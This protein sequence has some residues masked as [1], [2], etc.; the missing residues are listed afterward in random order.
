MRANGSSVCVVST[1]SQSF[2]LDDEN[3]SEV[4]GGNFREASGIDNA[5]AFFASGPARKFSVSDTLNC[6]HTLQTLGHLERSRVPYDR[7]TP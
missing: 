1:S 4:T 6:E 5:E 2:D 7:C 3:E